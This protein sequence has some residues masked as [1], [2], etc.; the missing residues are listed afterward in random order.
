M[1]RMRGLTPPAQPA[2]T[3]AL[4]V[5]SFFCLW[6]ADDLH[7]LVGRLLFIVGAHA[8]FHPH[9][10]RLGAGLFLDGVERGGQRARLSRFTDG[11]I[12]LGDKHRGV[13][14]KRQPHQ[15]PRLWPPG[16]H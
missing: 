1:P 3:A 8:I 2:P 16:R 11:R 7:G 5:R 14:V 13:E 4:A 6:G 9:D 15:C 10:D 12:N